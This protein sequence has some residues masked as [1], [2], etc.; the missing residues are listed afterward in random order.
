MPLNR[1]FGIV[2]PQTGKKYWRDPSYGELLSYAS[3]TKGVCLTSTN[4]TPR[5]SWTDPTERD[6]HVAGRVAGG[7]GQSGA[8]DPAG[9]DLH[10]KQQQL[11]GASDRNGSSYGARECAIFVGRTSYV[12]RNSLYELVHG[13]C[14]SNHLFALCGCRGSCGVAAFYSGYPEWPFVVLYLWS[15]YICLPSVN[16]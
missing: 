3:N 7:P 5:F 13:G 14:Y 9:L 2:C 11:N 10:H 8:A 16:K 1:A 4:N 6:A 12:V 15:L